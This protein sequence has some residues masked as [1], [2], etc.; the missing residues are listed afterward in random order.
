MPW[1]LSILLTV[2]LT[3]CTS[4]AK[5]AT[6]VTDA[7]VVGGWRAGEAPADF[8]LVVLADG[9]YHAEQWPL[10]LACGVA[11]AKSAADVSWDDTVS[12]EG[13]WV[14]HEGSGAS[15]TIFSPSEV[16]SG[17]SPS[18]SLFI[19]G[20]GRLTLNFYLEVPDLVDSTTTVVFYR[21]S[22]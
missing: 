18:A 16:C 13:R 10:N 15:M 4:G 21:D 12:L 17:Y 20:D 6:E 3:G 7:D 14:L 9:T 2:G 22:R 11:Q 8:E 19:E 5:P 1:A